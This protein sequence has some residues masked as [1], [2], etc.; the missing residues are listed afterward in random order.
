MSAGRGA[1][2]ARPMSKRGTVGDEIS[3]GR[4]AAREISRGWH[5]RVNIHQ[6]PRWPSWLSFE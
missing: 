2:R 5:V 1:V 4:F 6:I 3:L